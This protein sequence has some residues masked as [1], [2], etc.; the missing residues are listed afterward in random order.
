MQRQAAIADA[1]QP[2]RRQGECPAAALRIGG[3]AAIDGHRHVPAVV[4]AD[5]IDRDDRPEIVRRR[6]ERRSAARKRHDRQ[7]AAGGRFDQLTT[8]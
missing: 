5:Q 2:V 6:G 3:I 8:R 7:R 1:D 4:T